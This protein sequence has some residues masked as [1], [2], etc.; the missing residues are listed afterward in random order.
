MSRLFDLART[1]NHANYV[2]S[3]P[4]M[5]RNGRYRQLYIDKPLCVYVCVC[6]WAMKLTPVG[7]I[8]YQPKLQLTLP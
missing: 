3:V 2:P 8:L 6:V 1:V 7:D 4:F 5:Y